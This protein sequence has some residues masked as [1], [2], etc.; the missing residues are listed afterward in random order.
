M[1]LSCRST[2]RAWIAWSEACHDARIGFEGERNAGMGAVELYTRLGGWLEIAY[3]AKLILFAGD[4]E[5]VISATSLKTAAR[6][7]LI[8]ERIC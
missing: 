1:G 5:R 6:R 3:H 8:F 2:S 4:V 7:A